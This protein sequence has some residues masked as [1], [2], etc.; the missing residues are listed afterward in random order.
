MR[1][2]LVLIIILV[3]ILGLA[4]AAQ[5]Y[6]PQLMQFSPSAVIPTGAP[7]RVKI[8]T[9]ESITI[10]IVKKAGSSVVTVT[11]QSTNPQSNDNTSPFDFGPFG[12][13]FGFGTPQQP[14]QTQPNQPDTIGSGFIITGDG[15]IVT[16]KHVVSDTSM[17][18][19]VVT[20]DDKKY[21]VQ[22][23]YRD[24][25]NDVALL[26]IDPGENSG[27][28]LTPLTLGDSSHLQVGQYVVAIGTALGEFRNTV[29]TGIVSGLGRGITAG[30]PFEGSVEQLDNV[31]QTSAAI[32]PG[33]SGGPLLNSSDQVIGVNTAV[34][35]SGQNIGFAIPINVI[36]DSLNNFNQTGQFNRPY[37][38]VEY[39]MISKDLAIL[40]DLPEGA[41]VQN[42]LQG[43][44]ADTAGVQQGDVII[45]IDGQ[46]VNS[47]NQLSSIIAKKKT[48]D[49][50]TITLYR[51][52]KTI[53]VQATLQAAPQQ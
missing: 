34:S 7:E 24:P 48:A 22:K 5:K 32:N 42:V 9:E 4:S 15:M 36:K 43:S 31:I 3:V 50:I 19:Q 23:I 29:T 26:K 39:K 41:Y 46:R 49:K 18:Y 1:R 12:G 2:L 28:T 35:Q 14:D 21:K 44:P 38:G 53:D 20:S 37:L 40:N 33:N 17:T 8:V 30:S 45:K 51:D 25:L 6:A 11:G 47:S 52:S 13:F 16:N 27:K 10:D